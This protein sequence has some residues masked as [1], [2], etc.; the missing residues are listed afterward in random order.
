VGIKRRGKGY[1]SPPYRPYR[2]ID[3]TVEK[4]HSLN[5]K[6][7]QRGRFVFTVGLEATGGRVDVKRE[8]DQESSKGPW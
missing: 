4:N 5:I 7:K 3:G 1:N 2:G 6:V 8:K